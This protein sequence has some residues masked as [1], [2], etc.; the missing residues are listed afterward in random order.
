MKNKK[1]I[2]IKNNT[3]QIESKKGVWCW[4]TNGLSFEPNSK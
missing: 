3:I 1:A 4:K 2:K